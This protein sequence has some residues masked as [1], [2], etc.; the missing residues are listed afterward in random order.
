[1]AIEIDELGH[2]DRNTNYEIKRQ[3]EREKK[4]NYVFIRTNT[5]AADLNMNRLKSQ[6]YKHII[7]SKEENLK[8]KFTKELLTY[9]SS[10]FIPLKP[11]KYFV[12]KYFPHCKKWKVHKDE[13]DKTIWNNVLVWV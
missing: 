5:D 12:K 11:I 10:I 8:S 3:R 7:K 9:P 1:M 2:N 4:L 13:T 6:I